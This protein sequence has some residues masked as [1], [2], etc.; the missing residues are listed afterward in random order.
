M[1]RRAKDQRT[2]GK[3]GIGPFLYPRFLCNNLVRGRGFQGFILCPSIRVQSCNGNQNIVMNGQHLVRKAFYFALTMLFNTRE[4]AFRGGHVST[5]LKSLKFWKVS[6]ISFFSRCLHTPAQAQVSPDEE[7]LQALL[8]NLGELFCVSGA[9][10]ANLFWVFGPPFWSVRVSSSGMNSHVTL[11][12]RSVRKWSRLRKVHRSGR[13]KK[14]RKVLCCAVREQG[15]FFA[16]NHCFTRVMN[17]CGGRI[18]CV[19]RRWMGS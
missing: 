16:E 6:S 9:A 10:Q 17:I 1:A 11:R 2:Q 12:R 3:I 14:R 8:H 7:E 19:V 13:T 18:S 15:K 5:I 4:L